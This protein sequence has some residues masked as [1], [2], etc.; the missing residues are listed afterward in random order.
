MANYTKVFAD[1]YPNGWKS[2]PD[3]STPY[4]T[5]IHD[6]EDATFRSIENYLFENPIDQ[7]GDCS[8]GDLL[9]VDIPVGY[10]LA[11]GDVLKYNLS[12]HKF[13]PGQASGG[14]DGSYSFNEEVIGTDEYD[15]TLYSK[16]RIITPADIFRDDYIFIANGS[17]FSDTFII[18]ENC[19]PLR[20]EALIYFGDGTVWPVPYSNGTTGSYSSW[21]SIKWTTQSRPSYSINAS[22]YVNQVAQ[23]VKKIRLYCEYVKAWAN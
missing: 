7:I 6:N 21:A 16:T 2:K 8:V 22:Y 19:K 14:K 5:S 11:D 1:P 13:Q 9:D 3:L 20:V 17:G 12:T 10:T 4:L 23:Q 18:S 15:F